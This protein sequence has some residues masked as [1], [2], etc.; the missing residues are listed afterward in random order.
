MISTSRLILV[1]VQNHDRTDIKQRLLCLPTLYRY[2]VE[3][4]ERKR[5][6]S[7][8]ASDSPCDEVRRQYWGIVKYRIHAAAQMGAKSEPRTLYTKPAQLSRHGLI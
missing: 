7:S 6:R 1:D 8:K 2:L 3:H 5:I 4:H